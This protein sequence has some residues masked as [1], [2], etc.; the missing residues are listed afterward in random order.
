MHDLIAGMDNNLDKAQREAERDGQAWLRMSPDGLVEFVPNATIQALKDE[1]VRA[2][3]AMG[4]E[5]RAKEEVRRHF[6]ES[7]LGDPE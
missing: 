2:H 6:R 4:Y 1:Y 5:A 3:L 7:R